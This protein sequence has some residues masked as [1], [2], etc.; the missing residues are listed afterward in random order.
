MTW[1]TF[2]IPCWDEHA[3]S[4]ECSKASTGAG[5]RLCITKACEDVS[6]DAPEGSAGAQSPPLPTPLYIG[7]S[8]ESEGWFNFHPRSPHVWGCQM[9]QI[10]RV[11]IWCEVLSAGSGLTVAFHLTCLRRTWNQGLKAWILTTET[12]TQPINPSVKGTSC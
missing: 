6:K 7:L 11:G 2:F 8:G 4:W 9:W 10:T 12:P 3:Q 1:S 5:M